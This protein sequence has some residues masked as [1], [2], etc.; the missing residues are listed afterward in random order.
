MTAK[1]TERYGPIFRAVF[2]L[3]RAAI[4][5]GGALLIASALM[6]SVD[7]VIRKFTGVTLGGADELSSYA[8]AISTTWALAY[9]ALHRANIRV[10]ALYQY[11][12][13]RV[14][15]VVDWLALL[16][17]GI[18]IGTLSWYAYDVLAVSWLQNSHANTPLGTPLWIPQAMWFAGLAW[19]C[20]V[21]VMMLSRATLALLTGDLET[22]RALCGVRTSQEEAREE[23]EA[24]AR[25][26]QAESEGAR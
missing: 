15:A 1:E 10:D 8:F 23:A 7:V 4:W 11:F 26:V 16:G 9:V 21:L 24:G 14:A 5:G 2:A 13:V 6:I 18:F 12:P 20:F 25:I 22:V 17:L 3:S 19:M